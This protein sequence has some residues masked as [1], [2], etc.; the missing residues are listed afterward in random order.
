MRKRININTSPKRIPHQPV[1]PDEIECLI[2][3]PNGSKGAMEERLLLHTL[4]NL[5]NVHGYG[6]LS[7]LTKELED[8]WAHPEKVEEYTK[9][10]NRH[11]ETLKW[12]T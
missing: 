11:V 12:K 2:M 3:W 6:R 5:A 9:M 10:R 8:V 1:S 7:Q 4:I